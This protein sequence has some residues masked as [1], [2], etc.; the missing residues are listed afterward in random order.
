MGG[1]NS[2]PQAKRISEEKAE[3]YKS[4]QVNPELAVVPM[5]KEHSRV[6]R[7]EFCL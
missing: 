5:G 6:S 7:E 3:R 4:V 1:K 2:V